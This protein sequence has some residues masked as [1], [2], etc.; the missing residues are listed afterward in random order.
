MGWGNRNSQNK[1]KKMTMSARQ[2]PKD[3][4]AE[5]VRQ[6]HQI[7]QKNELFTLSERA[8]KTVFSQYNG[9]TCL[10]NILIKV[11]VLNTLYG[12]NIRDSVTV[13]RHIK[14]LD[15][16]ERV[17][18]GDKSL[19]NELAQ[20]QFSASKFNFYSFASKYCH[21]HNLSYP[22]YDSFVEDLLVHYQIKDP[23]YPFISLPADPQKKTAIRAYLK[24]YS[25]FCDAIESFKQKYNLCSF[26]TEELDHFLWGY[27]RELKAV[28]KE[29]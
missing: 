2:L 29:L 4:T 3:A 15:I 11:C 6:Y 21:F 24:D 17:M 16:D 27:G 28:S 14:N 22:L 13:A 26:S 7:F 19:V 10:D 18:A 25:S 5:L 12:T 8:V 9:N 20:V 1:T 23:K